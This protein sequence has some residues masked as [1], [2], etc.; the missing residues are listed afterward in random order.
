MSQKIA[1]ALVSI[2]SSAVSDERL[3]DI[4]ENLG[5]GGEVHIQDATLDEVRTKLLLA[6][7]VKVAKHVKSGGVRAQKPRYEKGAAVS[8]SEREKNVRNK[9]WRRTLE[10]ADDG[11]LVEEGELEKMEGVDGE[12][13]APN[14]VGKRMPCKDCT[15]GLK[16]EMDGEEKDE[17]NGKGGEK[18]VTEEEM[19]KASAC[20]NC[21]LGD[22]FRCGGCP[23]LG[24]EPFKEGEKVVISDALMVGDL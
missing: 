17:K 24:M 5:L 20:G 18:K 22:A 15:C 14:G 1:Q 9:E 2:P 21:S 7:F 10:G 12:A 3:A 19:N 4:Y 6:G 13:C 23:Y 8:I 16:E 11:E